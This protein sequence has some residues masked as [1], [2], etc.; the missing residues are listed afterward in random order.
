MGS[1]NSLRRIS[2]RGSKFNIVA[3]GKEVTLDSNSI[4][5]VIVNAAP[6]SRA[7]YGDA[8]DPNRVAVPTCWSSDT[9][10]PLVDVPQEQR[11]AMRCMDCPQNIR[12]SG[13][14]GGRACRFSQ[15][16]AVV[17][18]DKPEEV[19]QLQ[20]PAT[21]IFGSATKGDMGMQNYARLLAKHDTPVVTITTQVSF[22]GDSAVPKLCFKP[23]DRLDKDTLEI[24]S[25]MIDHEDTL[26]AITMSVPVTSEPVSP[27]SVVEGF[28]LN[29]N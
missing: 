13:Q 12:G 16:L 15:R 9:Q 14:Y 27:F 6:V 28:E 1:A 10:V 26:Q 21:S 24:V 29:A 8:Y 23:V 18:R 3:D 2:I 17:F 19:Y 25:T 22:V 5:V 20:I 11:Q 4:D 7:Y